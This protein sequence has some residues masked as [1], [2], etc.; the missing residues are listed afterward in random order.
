MKKYYFLIIVTLILGLVLT[1]CSLLSNISQVPAT[2]QSGITYLTKGGTPG[3]PDI[4]ILYAD[5]NIDVGTVSVWDDSINLY[6]EYTITGDWEMTETHLY[7][8][9]TN[10]EDLTSAPGQFPYSAKHRPAVDTY[11]Y[12]IPILAIDSYSL[13]KGKKWVAGE[14]YG[15]DPGDQIYIAVHA[16]VLKLSGNNILSNP[17]AE[18]GNMDNW[19]FSA[20]VRA[21]GS[22]PE[23]TGIVLPRTGG[24]FFDTTGCKA[25][26]ADMSQEVNVAGF[27]GASFKVSGWIQTERYPKETDDSITAND[28]GRLVVTFYDNSNDELE[29]FTTV[30]IGNPVYGTGSDGYAQFSLEGNIPDGAV[31]AIYELRGTLVLPGTYVNVFYDD[32]FFG[33]WQE[34]TAWAEGTRFSE[35]GNWATYFTY[36]Y[37]TEV[38]IPAGDMF[39]GS[40]YDNEY[41]IPE[42]EG[43]V[44]VIQP[45]DNDVT[46]TVSA[47]GLALN[48][49]YKVFFDTNGVT[50]DDVTTAGPW[51]FKGTFLTDGEGHGVWTYNSTGSLG[52][53]SY[54]WAVAINQTFPE[55]PATVLISYNIEFNIN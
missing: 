29:S 44:T 50:Q 54:T 34:E 48:S 23:S 25:E 16:K 53:G 1:G 3:D 5:Q 12:T 35:Q 40:V 7:V 8:G 38:L 41:Q 20:S 52:G 30:P 14:N 9:K 19:I 46:L 24:Y 28:Y 11:T 42:A 37:K 15:I 39:P 13:V 27:D 2:D 36:L 51:S 45:T 17:D 18:T 6:V 10:P 22:A 21:I 55:T 26:S 49:E 32:L 4:F 33:G 43:K 31:T 47:D